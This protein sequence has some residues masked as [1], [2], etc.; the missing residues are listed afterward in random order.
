MDLTSPPLAAALFETTMLLTSSEYSH[1]ALPRSRL[2]ASAT[3]VLGYTA[4]HDRISGTAWCIDGRVL[5]ILLQF[6][7]TD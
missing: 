2:Q 3:G 5:G 6:R 7:A 4:F 1:R